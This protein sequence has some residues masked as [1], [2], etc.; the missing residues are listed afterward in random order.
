MLLEQM[1]PLAMRKIRRSAKPAAL[2]EQ[3]L[4]ALMPG[5]G[6]LLELFCGTGP[7]SLAA[8]KLG[9]TTIAVDEDEQMTNR[10]NGS[11]LKM[12]TKVR[13]FMYLMSAET[14]AEISIGIPMMISFTRFH[15][16]LNAYYCLPPCRW[17]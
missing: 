9:F 15:I 16:I 3:L 10:L 2:A 11:L 4:K 14:F 7:F 12:N 6:V 13:I 8:A 1:A 5:G 17:R